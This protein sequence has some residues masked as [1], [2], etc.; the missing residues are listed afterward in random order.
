MKDKANID[1]PKG[2]Q[3][4]RILKWKG[5]LIFFWY[6]KVYKKWNGVALLEVQKVI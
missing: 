3:S 4:L 2:V 5:F 1:Y 6:V